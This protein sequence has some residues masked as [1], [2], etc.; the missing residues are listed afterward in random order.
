MIRIFLSFFFCVVLT[1]LLAQ[2]PRISSFSLEKTSNNKV[3]VHWTMNAGSTCPNLQVERWIN[4]GF[5][6]V[7]TY[8]SVCG[9]SDVEI[10][11]WWIDNE[12]PNYSVAQYRI[13]LEEAEFTLPQNIDLDSDLKDQAIILYPNPIQ[14]GQLLN[15]KFRNQFERL[16]YTIHN[17]L[18]QIVNQ[19]LTK[20]SLSFNLVAE[21]EKGI[22]YLRIESPSVEKSVRFIVR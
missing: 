14:S 22:Y 17:S 16:N 18:G 6:T 5:Q 9:D 4:G 13:K 19:G 11:Y 21:L 15:V 1:H 10:D 3:I 7:Y 12:V 8:P 2:S 20:P